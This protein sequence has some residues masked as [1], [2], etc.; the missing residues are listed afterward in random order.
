MADDLAVVL[1]LLQT[2]DNPWL[3][4]RA[5]GEEW[6][7]EARRAAAAAARAQTLWP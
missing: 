6:V 1:E 2:S 7:D 3:T 4:L 5:E